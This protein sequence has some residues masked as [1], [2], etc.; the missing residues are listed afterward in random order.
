MQSLSDLAEILLVFHGDFAQYL[1]LR[2]EFTFVASS[3]NV[4]LL[5]F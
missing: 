2:M 1:E 4:F 5:F 3:Y